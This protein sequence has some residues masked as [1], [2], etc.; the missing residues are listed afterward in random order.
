[1]K[2]NRSKLAQV[3]TS[4]RGSE[5]ISLLNVFI[6]NILTENNIGSKCN[7]EEEDILK[8]VAMRCEY[9]LRK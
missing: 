7:W 3:I 2:Q 4:K 8:F 6:L 1:M 5:G 9:D